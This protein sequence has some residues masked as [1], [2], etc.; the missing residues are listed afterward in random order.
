MAESVTRFLGEDASL[1]ATIQKLEGRLDGFGTQLTNV[2]NATNGW[3][4][5]F[6]KAAIGIATLAAGIAGAVIGIN[7]F[8]TALDFV[9]KLERLKDQTGAAGNELLLFQRALEISGGSANNVAPIFNKLQDAISKAGDDS[10]KATAALGLLNM[11][12]RDLQGLSPGEQVAKV[13]NALAA[14]PDPADRARAAI[15]IFGSTLAK[16]VLPMARDF[17]GVMNKAKESLGSLPDIINNFGPS[18]DNF[19]T[20]MDLLKKIPENFAIGVVAPMSTL[21]GNLA[22]K[23]AQFDAAGLGLAIGTALNNVL[24]EIALW[25]ENV[26]NLLGGIWNG[27]GTLNLGPILQGAFNTFIEFVDSAKTLVGTIYESLRDADFTSIGQ[28]LGEAIAYGLEPLKELNTNPAAALDGFFTRLDEQTVQFGANLSTVIV[29]ALRAGVEQANAFENFLNSEQV[30]GIGERLANGLYFALLNFPKWNEAMSSPVNAFKMMW[31]ASQEQNS[32]VLKEALINAFKMANSRYVDL[33]TNPAK[34][35]SGMLGQFLSD[36]FLS[37]LKTFSSAWE[38]T[39]GTIIQK[40]KAAYDAVTENAGQ[41]MIGDTDTA[42]QNITKG[43]DAL[44]QGSDNLKN[45]SQTAKDNIAAAKVDVTGSGGISPALDANADALNETANKT[46]TA[47]SDITTAFNGVATS[48]NDFKSSTSNAGDAFYSRVTAA[49]RAL[50]QNLSNAMKQ[51]TD[52][53]RGFATEATLRQ[54][55]DELRLIK[56]KVG[57]PVLVN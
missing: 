26:S 5:A 8:Q 15:A 16:D 41:K 28:R 19:K 21:L 29:E 47:S 2:G 7:T 57:N 44:T 53:A 20:N 25:V 55:V 48:G 23:F 1:G 13:M 12:F 42:S 39:N 31:G 45:A 49:G 56:E 24:V 30:A 37:F 51:L 34:L 9:E 17:D 46:Q 14:I 4:A 43:A 3:P 10:P 36:A 11:T 38:N 52:S 18:L 27:L 32:N 33:F 50:E 35:A 6:T 40:F 22:G 54:A